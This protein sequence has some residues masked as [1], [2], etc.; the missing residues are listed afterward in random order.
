MASR[1]I[2][3]CGVLIVD[4]PGGCTSHDVV[5]WARRAFSTREVGH[6]GT[7]DPMATGVLVVLIGEAT[8][9]STW[10]TSE[11]K[12]YEAELCFGR[13]TDTLDA[14]GVVTRE[15]AAPLLDRAS[16]EAAA[17]SMLGAISQTPPAVSAIKVGGVAA[18]ER[19]R[20]GE[21]V[22]LPPREVVLRDV[23]I[24]EVEGDRARMALSVSKG[25]YVR[26]FARDL[27]AKLGTVA[28]LTA[29]R[30]TRSG[31]FSLSNALDGVRLRQAREDEPARSEA[32][33]R[34]LPL[35]ALEGQVA[36]VR[37]DRECAE[38]LLRGKRPLAPASASIDTQLV[39]VDRGDLSLPP[40][41]IGLAAREGDVLV[42]RRNLLP[43]TVLTERVAWLDGVE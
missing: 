19:V 40:Q 3:P 26:S 4:K 2:P 16:V 17:R 33:G 12:S 1:E 23:E 6:A 28:H 9:L 35:A 7:L 31:V 43:G 41:P 21:V 25:F 10:V 42:A 29:L 30:R 8:K 11:D 32:R 22:E 5:A 18:H 15:L 24:T 39:L 14:D 34:L 13:E 27:A 20:R 38:A 37:V 36:T